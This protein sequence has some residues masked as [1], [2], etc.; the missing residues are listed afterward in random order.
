MKLLITGATGLVGS[1]IVK[2][3][4]EQ[5]IE[6]NYLTTRRSAVTQRDTYTGFYW[7]PEKKQIDPKCFEGVSAIINLAGSPIS[8]R[9]T[10]NTKR[11]ILSS[12]INSLRTL[13]AGLEQCEKPMPTQ[14]ITAS[15]ISVYPDSLSAFYAED[16]P[17]VD[18]SFPAEVVCAW[19]AEADALEKFGL[20][21]AKIRIGLVLS[22]EGGALREIAKPIKNYVGAALG[23][24][25]QWQSWIHIRDLARM[26]LFILEEQRVGVYNGVA[27]NPV[28]HNKLV[29]EIANA[30]HKPLLL[31]NIPEFMMRLLLGEMAYL[32]FASQRVS[33]KKIENE[34]F[35][36]NHPNISGA[37]YDLYQTVGGD[38]IETDPLRNEFLG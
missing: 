3:C 35:E 19:E 9:W 27:P 34:G 17:T 38:S 10:K 30:L 21:V 22:T 25:E 23:S 26:F 32:L 4:H 8:K 14:L 36:F 29:R 24:G 7:D 16:E 12:R 11:R 37:L 5:D 15:G 31:P 18:D 1:S 33:S 6:V 2:L 13:A 20:T 28:T